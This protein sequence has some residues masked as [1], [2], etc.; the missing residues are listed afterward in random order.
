[1]HG[2]H[3]DSKISRMCPYRQAQHG[4]TGYDD[5]RLFQVLPLYEIKTTPAATY[6]PSTLRYEYHRPWWA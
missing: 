1:M 4:Q 6:S 3:K 5:N 2:K